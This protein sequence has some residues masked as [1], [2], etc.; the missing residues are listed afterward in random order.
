MQEAVP[1]RLV[2][3]GA[4]GAGVAALLA[5]LPDPATVTPASPGPVPRPAP[6]APVRATPTAPTQEASPRDEPVPDDRTFDLVIAG[7][8]VIDPD[9][10]FDGSADVGVTGG[11][12]EAVGPGPLRGRRTI[13][14]AGRVVAPGFIDLLSYDPNDYGVWYKV[15][16]GV[17]SNLG[18][19]G[20]NSLPEQWF[21]TFAEERP[22]VHYG[23][24]FDHA[25]SRA[26]LGLDPYGAASAQQI[27]RLRGLAT[28]GLDGGW[29]GVHLE[30]EYTPGVEPAEAVA[31]AEVAAAAGVGVYVHG[32]YSDATPPGTN[33]DTLAEILGLARATGAPVHVE[34][35]PS[36]GG[37]FTME[38]SLATLAAARAEGID[39]TACMYPYDFWAT[40]LGSARFADGWQERFRISYEDLVVAGSGER[41]TAGTFNRARAANLLVAALAIPEDDVRA[42]LRSDMVLIGSD[43][44]L[45]PGDNNH[46]RAAGCFSRVLGRY[47]RDEAV[48]SL[49]SALAKM[50]ILPARRLEAALPAMARKGRLQVGCDADITVFDPATVGDRA[51]LEDPSQESV[52]VEWVLVGGEVVKTPDGVQRDVRPG[53]PLARG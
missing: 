17:T 18:M 38:E 26:R 47:V 8:R 36:T 2:L 35:L 37:T 16:D 31:M 40:Y 21:A 3:T 53:Q 52:G 7:G 5:K 29:A 48:L 4:F 28:E 9:T 43:A 20:V 34:H 14:A 33:A 32:R 19:H 39:V 1:R 42:G 22:P 44:I 27:D 49:P 15:A 25:W 30:L 11:R 50:T 41:L 13:D 46:P 6:V 12:I 45:E 23:G 51:T 10:G 24:A